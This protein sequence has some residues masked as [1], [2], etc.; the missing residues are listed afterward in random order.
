MN[1]LLLL[2]L[3]ITPAYAA[4]SSACLITGDSIHWIADYCM[5]KLETDDEIAA[6]D[7]INDELQR[8]FPDDC[9]AKRHYKR[10]LCELAIARETIAGTVESC[11]ADKKFM[12]S[13]V[14]NGGVGN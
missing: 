4:D 9:A 6:S 10:A 7:C 14:E 2:P 11:V 1:I 8:P 5:A 12:G 3:L 13:T